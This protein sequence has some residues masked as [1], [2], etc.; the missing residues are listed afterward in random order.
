MEAPRGIVRHFHSGMVISSS[1]FTQRWPDWPDLRLSELLARLRGRSPRAHGSPGQMA[2]TDAAA[3]DGIGSNRKLP[4]ISPASMP[5]LW[6]EGGEVAFYSQR[7]NTLLASRHH[8]VLDALVSKVGG[9]VSHSV[10]FVGFLALI[11]CGCAA[12][13]AAPDGVLSTRL[14]QSCEPAPH[15]RGPPPRPRAPRWTRVRASGIGETRWSSRPICRAPTDRPPPPSQVRLSDPVPTPDGV[16]CLQEGEFASPFRW[17]RE[18]MPESSH[19]A[20]FE[21]VT[22]ASSAGALGPARAAAERVPVVCACA[23][24]GPESD[25]RPAA[26]HSR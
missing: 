12:G 4:S 14:G 22:P 21:L 19:L 26:R 23:R 9:R 17:A 24:A 10:E 16:A 25:G 20:R 15:L 8:E 6:L 1:K 11:S 5:W 18:D 7:L 3:N 13:Q 2:A